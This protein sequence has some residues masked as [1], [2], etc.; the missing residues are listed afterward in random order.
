[1]ITTLYKAIVHRLWRNDI[2]KLGKIDHGERLTH[3]IAN[4]VSDPIRLERIVQDEENFLERLAM[5]LTKK[6]K[7]SL[8]VEI[9]TISSDNW[10][11]RRDAHCLSV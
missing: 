3:E 7:S 1:M 11:V 10:R 9:L 4:S 8:L 6:T 5:E 2:P